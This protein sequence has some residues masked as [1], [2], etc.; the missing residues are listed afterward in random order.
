MLKLSSTDLLIDNFLPPFSVDRCNRPEG[1]VIIYVRDTLTC[2]RRTDLELQNREAVWIEIEVKT[3][4]FSLVVFIE[5]LIV[6]LIT[7]LC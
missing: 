1:G 2:K 3:K 5:H 4:I 7:S 6:M